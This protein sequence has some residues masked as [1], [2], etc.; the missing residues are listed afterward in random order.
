MGFISVDLR[1]PDCV[2]TEE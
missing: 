1:R 2:W